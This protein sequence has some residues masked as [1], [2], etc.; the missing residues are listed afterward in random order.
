MQDTTATDGPA[1]TTRTVAFTVD[2]KGCIQRYLPGSPTSGVSVNLSLM[3]T[4][5]PLQNGANRTG[6]S[7]SAR[8][9]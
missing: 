1:T 8:L 7:F 4:G 2:V 9:P 3:A 5:Q 6:V